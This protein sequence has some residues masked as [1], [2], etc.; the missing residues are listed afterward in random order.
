MTSNFEC[1]LSSKDGL[2]ICHTKTDEKGRFYF[3]NISLGSFQIRV[4][5]TKNNLLFNMKPDSQFVYLTRH[6]NVNVKERFIL[7]SVTV[8]SQFFL[9]ENVRIFVFKRF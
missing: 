9:S 5:L 6:Q 4:S 8:K 2:K 7:D 1:D 3:G